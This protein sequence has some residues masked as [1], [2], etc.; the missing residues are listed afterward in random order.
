MTMRHFWVQIRPLAQQNILFGKTID[1]I[2][3]YFLT[4]FIEENFKKSLE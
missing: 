3:I 2:F 4:I 1:L